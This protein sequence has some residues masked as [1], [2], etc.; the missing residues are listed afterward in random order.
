MI[1]G[2]MFGGCVYWANICQPEPGVFPW[3]FYAVALT[4]YALSQVSVYCMFVAQMAFHARIS[5]PV[6]GGTYMTLLNTVANLGGNWPSTVAL[7]LV[8]HLTWRHCTAPD[9]AAGDSKDAIAACEA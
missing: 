2:L 3:Y 8:D 1:I 4:I 7:W 5:D 9:I 6:I